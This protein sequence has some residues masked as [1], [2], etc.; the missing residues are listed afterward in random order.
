MINDI[1]T[2]EIMPLLADEV[3]INIVIKD[4]SM[5]TGLTSL[6]LSG[7]NTIKDISMLTGLTSLNLLCNDTIKNISMLTGLTFL[8]LEDNDRIIK[9]KANWPIMKQCG[10]KIPEN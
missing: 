2:Y 7:N 1:L 9:N 3:I 5:L 4:I 10:C 8:N 6:N